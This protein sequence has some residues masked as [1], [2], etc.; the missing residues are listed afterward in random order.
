MVRFSNAVTQ[1]SIHLGGTLSLRRLQAILEWAKEYDLSEVKTVI[2][3]G[4]GANWVEAGKGEFAR[5]VMQLDGFH[6]ARACGRGLGKELG[7]H[8]E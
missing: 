6:L 7:R 1:R 8:V 2:V 4:D 3:R 5:S